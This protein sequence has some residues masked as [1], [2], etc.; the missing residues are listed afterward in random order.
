MKAHA[1]GRLGVTD[2]H[3]PG[4][5]NILIHTD[6]LYVCMYVRTNFMFG[7]PICVP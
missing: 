2:V 3:L 6:I 7:W 1:V 4:N 5:R